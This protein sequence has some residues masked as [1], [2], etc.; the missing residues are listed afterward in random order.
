[1]GAAG[2]CEQRNRETHRELDATAH[3]VHPGSTPIF[4]G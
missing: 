2:A 3:A 4:V 1:M